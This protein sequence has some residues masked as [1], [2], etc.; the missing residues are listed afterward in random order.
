MGPRLAFTISLVVACGLHALFLLVPRAPGQSGDKVPTIELM[1][2]SAAPARAEREAGPAPVRRAAAAAAAVLPTQGPAPAPAPVTPSEKN[3]VSLQP[4]T[5]EPA[6][7]SSGANDLASAP[8][9]EAGEAGTAGTDGQGEGAAGAP[10]LIPPHPKADIIVSYPRSASRAGLEGT[11]RIMASIN[12]SGVLIS[13][14]VLSSS[15][16][17][18]LDKAALQAVQHTSFEP[19]LQAGRTVPCRLIIPVR[20]KLN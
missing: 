14:E 6:A 3:E 17:D 5:M 7:G 20:F 1:F 4:P 18:A 19:A 12:E 8:G 2:E 16:H 11:V 9:A 10:V 13:A 15:G